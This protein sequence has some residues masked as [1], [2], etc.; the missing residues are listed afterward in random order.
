[1]TKLIERM[2]EEL[3]RRNY[4]ETTIYTYLRVIEDFHLFAAKRLDHVTA[5]DIRRYHAHLLG[6]RKLAPHTVVLHVSRC[7]FCTAKRSSAAR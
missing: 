5:D 7:D 2:R 3:V 4:A 1:V 6:D